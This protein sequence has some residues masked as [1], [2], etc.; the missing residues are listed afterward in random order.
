MPVGQQTSVPVHIV[1]QLRHVAVDVRSASQPLGSMLSQSSKPE[2]QVKLQLPELH[3]ADMTFARVE[4]LTSDPQPEP[5]VAGEFRFT[6]Q[7]FAGLPSQ[8]EKP[9]LQLAM[10][11][12]PATVHMP[13]AF[14][15]EQ[16]TPQPPQLLLVLSRTSQPSDTR[17]LQS[18]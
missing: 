7:P 14:A 15:G 6:S 16:L 2:L 12:V 13:V 17:P 8:S 18:P 3:V 1:P 11:H 9:A 5:H 4:Q 10:P